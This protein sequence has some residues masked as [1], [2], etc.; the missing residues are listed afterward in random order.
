MFGESILNP[1][2]LAVESA[3]NEGSRMLVLGSS[4]ATYS[5]WRL[6]KQA[7]EEDMPI[8]IVNKGGVRGEEHF[9][10]RLPPDGSG[11]EGLRCSLS[12]E[13]VLPALVSELQQKPVL[14]L[15]QRDHFQPAPWR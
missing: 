7:K 14:G 1:V 2:K 3:I 10:A 8:A 12:L 13:E 4:L 5:A 6:V 9:L 15:D 11:K